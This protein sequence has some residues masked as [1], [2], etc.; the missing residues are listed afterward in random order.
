MRECYHS[1]HV[2]TAKFACRVRAE[3]AVNTSFRLLSFDCYGTLVDWETGLLAQLRPWVSRNGLVLS[4]DDLLAAFATAEATTEAEFPS[5]PYTEVLRRV[6]RRIAERFER[7]SSEADA[8][9]F[10]HSVGDWPM[11]PDTVA[12]LQDLRARHKLVILSNTDHASFARTQEKLGVEFDALVLAEDVGAYKPDRRMFDAMLVTAA[13]FDIA[14]HEILHVAE[15][16][17]HDH[18]PAKALG[19]ATAWIHRRHGREGSGATAPTTAVVQPD[20][21]ARSLRELVLLCGMQP[22]G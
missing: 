6:H 20:F 21:Y 4:D 13:R 5:L 10:A 3:R 11:F 12:A 22:H 19:L 8:A 15:S 1:T 17:Y 14:P 18:V 9:A 16:L 2:D 7:T